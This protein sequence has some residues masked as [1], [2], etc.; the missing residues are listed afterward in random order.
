VDAAD[1]RR[2]ALALPEVEEYEHG[3]LPAF[4]VRGKRFATMLDD[5][6]V[7]VMLGEEGILAAAASWPATCEVRHF[8][9]RIAALRVGYPAMPEDVVADLLR[10]AWARRAPKGLL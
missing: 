7:N 9:G 3:D 8:G 10:E 2:I 5:E 6:G 1:L 4:R